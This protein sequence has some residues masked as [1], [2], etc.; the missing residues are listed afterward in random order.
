MIHPLR[1]PSRERLLHALGDLATGPRG[2]RVCLVIDADRT[3]APQD[4]G[5]LVGRATGVDT[6]IRAIFEA[7]G[8][9]EE[10]FSLVAEVW[11]GLRADHYLAQVREVAG[12]VTIYAAWRT[13]LS[14]AR[15][16]VPVVVVTAGIPQAWRAILDR[17]GHTEV[18][19]VGGCHRDLDAY[20]VC[21]ETKARLVG[22]LQDAGWR[23]VAAGDSPIDLPMLR[24]ADVPLFVPDHNGSPAL[25]A[26]LHRVPGVRHLLV[27]ER[28]FDG[29]ATW[30]P[31]DVVG[32]IH[33]GGSRDAG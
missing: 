8:Y 3:L 33:E 26:E 4:T 27:D 5:R 11:S 21:P 32:L 28:R 14:A 6:A 15:G 30:R 22:V 1:S 19:V 29:L 17:L 18:P 13:I 9:V 2:G 24:R 16:R 12:A 23:V 25:R 31:E 10:A 7:R 20:V